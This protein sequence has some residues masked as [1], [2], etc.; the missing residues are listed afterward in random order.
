M[1]TRNQIKTLA[2]ALRLLH[3]RLLASVQVGFEKLHGRV[4]SAGGLLQLALHD[5]LFIWLAPMSRQI[6]ALDEL[7]ESDAPD[8]IEARASVARL[9]DEPSD[10][11]AS[12]LTC[13]QADPDVVMGHAAVRAQLRE[14]S[15]HRNG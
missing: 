7:A 4:E 9:L 8:L 15:L 12:Y 3:R 13:L 5:P 1:D 11:R 14:V 10:F 6:V 2:D